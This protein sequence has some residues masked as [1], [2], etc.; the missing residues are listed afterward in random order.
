MTSTL[1]AA[2]AVDPGLSKAKASVV[3]MDDDPMTLMLLRNHLTKAGFD[4]D[5]AIDGTSGLELIDESVS[6]ALVDLKMPDLSG[7][8]VLQH[9][10]S[11]YPNTNVIILT[12]STELDD[13][14]E[15][16][17]DGAFQF[18]TKPFD[19]AQLVV[20]VEKAVQNCQDQEEL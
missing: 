12:S 9:I 14:V 20:Y 7:F 4:V 13:A 16:M 6:V 2:T 19:P 8:Q 10:R 5:T 3:V 15:A 1:P 11:H 17:R 18:V